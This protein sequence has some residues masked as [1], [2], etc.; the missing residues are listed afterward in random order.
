MRRASK[1]HREA[2]P[3]HVPP[4]CMPETEEE[5]ER[6]VEYLDSGRFPRCEEGLGLTE[7][8]LAVRGA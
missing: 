6:I 4:I 8:E 2:L 5:A 7:K 1:E 3:P